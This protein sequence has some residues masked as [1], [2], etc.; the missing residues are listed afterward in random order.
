MKTQFGSKTF[1]QL[2]FRN[3][4]DNP[5]M[6]NFSSYADYLQVSDREFVAVAGTAPFHRILCHRASIILMQKK[7]SLH[8]IAIMQMQNPRLSTA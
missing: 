7:G 5:E 8:N 3:F 6:A 2:K 4:L 1:V